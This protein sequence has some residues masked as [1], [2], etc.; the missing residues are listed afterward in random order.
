[1][2][3]NHQQRGTATATGPTGAFY[4]IPETTTASGAPA[5]AQSSPY[6][7]PPG[8]QQNAGG[9]QHY[10]GGVDREQDSE[11]EGVWNSAM[12]W[13]QAAGKKLSDA[14]SEVWRRINKE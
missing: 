5:S 12:K 10:Q 4:Q 13:A 14:E 6:A 2:G 11:Q 8:Y 3:Y 7:H 9:Y 1:M